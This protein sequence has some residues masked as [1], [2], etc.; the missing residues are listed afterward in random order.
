M[1]R[2]FRNTIFYLLIF[3]VIVGIVSFFT[4]DQTQT[5]QITF[6]EFTQHLEAGEITSLS[7]KP[8]RDVY[9]VRGQLRGAD[10]DEFF[11]TYV[12]PTEQ[13]A[14]TISEA[15]GLEVI[16]ADETSGWVTF[17]TGIIPFIIIFILF[18]FLLSQA[19]GGGSRVM[20]FGKSKAKMV[21]EDKKKAKFKDVA[22]A[23]EEKQELVEVVEFLKDPRKF[24][25]IG[26]RIPKGVLLV[27]PPG[28]GKTLL[29]RA[30]AG[31]AGVPFFSI[32]GSDFVE[33]FVGVGASRV[34]DLFEN[35]KKNAPCIIFIDEIDAV[36]RQRGAGLGGGHDER[37]QTLNQLL[38]EMDGFSAN[39]GIII[40][41]ATNRADILDPALLRPG[42]FD[43]QITVGR[44]DVKGREEVLKVHASNK[45]L[46]DDVNL[47]TIA[48]RTPG[49]SGADLENLLNEA[50]LVAARQ[51][52]KKIS[53]VHI[54]EAID[55]VIAGP[56][57]KSRV[58]SEKEKN[59]VA[60]H[61]AGH[62]V[63]GVK[64][65]NAD[66]VHKVTIVPRGVAGGYA[67]MLPKE[68][69]YFMTKPELLDKIVGL[70][71]GRVAEEIQFGEAS[72]GAH[73]DFQRATSIAR[74]MVTEY[75]MSEKLGPMQF[76]SGSG[77]QVFLGRDIQNEQNYSDAI[78]H[79]IDLEV[80]RIIKECYERCKQ[81]LLD[82]KK[83]LDLVAE[84]LLDLETLDAEQIKSLIHDGKLPDNHHLAEKIAETREN[85]QDSE[86]KV[87]IHSKKGEE[88]EGEESAPN[89]EDVKEDDEKK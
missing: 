17:F 7:I 40:I 36:G 60:W 22:G 10:E 71:G 29:A 48:T 54:E 89:T 78:A 1:N 4:G 35:A 11:E 70:L 32:S 42:R 81:I 14:E 85:G 38:V 72:T 84:T 88:A 45:P 63:V 87:N 6:E 15:A 39:E 67:V 21:N 83:S 74:K 76:G 51:D 49:F 16:P 66:M 9:L 18:F 82:N 75:G 56:A 12:L 73:N 47:K 55:R 68:D 34:R 43:R 13:M 24:S 28:T 25:A 19:Q 69:R 50:A 23:D 61:E 86:V 79:E 33:M 52:E 65:E 27:G 53:M 58:I 46:A 64:L 8:E 80:Q 30:V 2:I 5:K 41:A 77:G 44:P 57:K 37:E 59:I 31:E 20:N 26:A 62:T 3:L